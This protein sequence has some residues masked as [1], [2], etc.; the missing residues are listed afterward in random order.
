MKLLS[1]FDRPYKSWIPKKMNKKVERLDSVEVDIVSHC[2]LNCKSCTHFSPLAK[3]WYIDVE[4]FKSDIER[5]SQILPDNRI[6]KLYILG[7]EPLL[8]S[9]IAEILTIAR[10]TYKK[11]TITIITNGFLLPKMD[12]TF[13]LVCE[14]EN[15]EIEITKYPI[16]YDYSQIEKL[17]HDMKGKVKIIYKGRTRF[18]KKK[19]YMLPIDDTGEQ[20]RV[21]S[22]KYCFMAGHCI[23]LSKG[24]LYTCSYAAFMDRFN[25]YFKKE[26]PVTE[27]DSV[28]IYQNY[29]TDEV[30]AKLSKP[31]PICCY[32]NVKSRTYGNEW[33][34][35][36]RKI[37][38][39]TIESKN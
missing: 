10:N 9:K 34:V 8:H 19:Q 21:E 18:L 17:I 39:W 1:Y 30:I 11:L 32:C 23:N 3:P 25:A 29:T 7:G 15:I 13:W 26:I 31:I 27:E 5:L 22:F 28:D 35:S 20:N 6:G 37:D 16:Q 36:K 38:E 24:K 14:K 33:G 12:K 2:N 4:D